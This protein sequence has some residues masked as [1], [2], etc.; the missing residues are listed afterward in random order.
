M[1]DRVVISD[2]PLTTDNSRLMP[3]MF[4]SQETVQGSCP[5]FG[6]EES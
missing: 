6:R 1:L 3:A 4:N 2:K 5:H